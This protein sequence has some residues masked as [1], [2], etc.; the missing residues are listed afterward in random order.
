MKRIAFALA[1]IL[2]AMSLAACDGITIN[3][4]LNGKETTATEGTTLPA[5]QTPTETTGSTEAPRRSCHGG[6]PV[7]QTGRM[8]YLRL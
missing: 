2:L 5:E 1:A 7:G 4:N 6:C 8:L 3:I